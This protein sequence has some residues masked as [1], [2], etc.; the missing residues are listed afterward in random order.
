VNEINPVIVIVAYDRDYPLKRLLCSISKA[1]YDS[2]VD[3]IISIDK[4]DNQ[5]VYDLAKSFEWQHGNKN[6]L[7][8][9]SHLGLKKHIIEC[10]DLVEKYDSVIILEDD[11]FVSPYFYKY[12][13]RCFEYYGKDEKISGISLYSHGLNETANMAFRPIDDD[14]DVFF[15]QIPSSWGQG[16]TKSQWQGFRN[17]FEKRQ[18]STITE[19]E[20]VPPNVVKWPES[21]WKKYFFAYMVESDKY[22]VYPRIS[23]STNFHDPGTHHKKTQTR[24]QVPLQFLEKNWKLIHFEESYAVYDGYLEILPEKLK[25]L[26]KALKEY[27]FEVDFYAQKDVKKIEKEYL[28]TSRNASNP[29]KTFGKALKPIELNV[30]C[31]IEGLKINLAKKEQCKE[32][33]DVFPQE[34]ISYYYNIPTYFINEEEQMRNKEE[35]INQYYYKYYSEL[36]T[37]LDGVYR[38]K[39]WKLTQPLRWVNMQV[40]R[41][42]NKKPTD[43][44]KLV[45]SRESES[46][47]LT[48]FDH[49]FEFGNFTPQEKIKIL[50]EHM[51]DKVPIAVLC[52]QYGIEREMLYDWQKE[53]FENGAFAFQA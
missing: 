25:D 35:L 17:W 34:D 12:A 9:T 38:S 47:N 39:S 27:D 5:K 53:L 30:I 13:E 45:N 31:G 49:L 46:K 43:E 42:L 3:L 26:S 11:L 48:A 2:A 20:N 14:S 24:L 19:A 8:K 1:L 15:L 41:L 6:V 29:A 51:I 16:W 40:K 7:E 44:I 37:T 18:F 50:K 33:F 10:G 36:K 21:S 23:L 28:L 32:N 22:V 52:K 4:N